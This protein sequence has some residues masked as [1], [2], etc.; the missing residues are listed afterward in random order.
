MAVPEMNRTRHFRGSLKATLHCGIIMVAFSK[1][2]SEYRA[3][4]GHGILAKTQT[5]PRIAAN[6]E[7]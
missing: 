1:R 2:R 5:C 3:S 6:T 7:K 4:A